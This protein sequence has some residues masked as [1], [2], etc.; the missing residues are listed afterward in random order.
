[1]KRLW[2][3]SCRLVSALAVSVS[4]AKGCIGIQV[5]RVTGLD[6]NIVRKDME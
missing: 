3:L 5:D 4:I 1:M 2:T 6:E